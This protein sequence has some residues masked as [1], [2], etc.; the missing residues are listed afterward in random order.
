MALFNLPFKQDGNIVTSGTPPWAKRL[1]KR[2]DNKKDEQDWATRTGGTTQP[3]SGRNWHRKLDVRN[4]EFLVDCKETERASYTI[5]VGQWEDLK[6]QA[7]TERRSPM[8]KISFLQGNGKKV[9]LV[10]VAA[11]FAE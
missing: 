8:L 3:N 5:T 6:R 2:L 10:V 1:L 11:E 4:D 9:E 7:N